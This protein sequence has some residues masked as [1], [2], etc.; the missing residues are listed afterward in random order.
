MW[1]ACSLLGSVGGRARREAWRLEEVPPRAGP[2]AGAGSPGA[3][4]SGDRSVKGRGECQVDLTVLERGPAAAL[5]L[6]VW[7]ETAMTS[8]RAGGPAVAYSPPVRIEGGRV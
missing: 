7:F 6:S 8:P 3:P 4:G 5:R 2:T 1:R